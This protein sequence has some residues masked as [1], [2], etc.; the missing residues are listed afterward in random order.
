[1]RSRRKGWPKGDKVNSRGEMA[2]KGV[3]QKIFN[4]VS[5]AF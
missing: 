4:Y 1:M 5:F 2:V 3:I